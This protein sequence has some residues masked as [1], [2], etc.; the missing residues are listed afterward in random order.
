MKRRGWYR[1]ALLGAIAIVLL[2]TWL[3]ARSLQTLLSTQ[4]GLEH[5]FQVID[6]TR[7]LVA[8]V[9]TAEA[10]ARGY[11]LTAAPSFEQQFNNVS[12][13]VD[14][15][16]NQVQSLTADNT[17]QQQ[18]VAVL[19]QRIAAKMEVLRD[20]IAVRHGHP[21]G[22]IDPSLLGA[23]VR[24]TPDNLESVQ[25]SIHDIQ[26]DEVALLAQRSR[27]AESARRQVKISFGVAFFLDF[28]LLVAAFRLLERV[29]LRHDQLHTEFELRLARQ[30][31]SATFNQAAVGMA[32]TSTEGRFLL[33]NERL[34]ES[35]QTP[36][37][38][39]L[40][41]RLWDF[42]LPSERGVDAV[43]YAEMLAGSRLGYRVER[44]ILRKDGTTFP[45]QLTASLLQ[46]D[47]DSTRESA[48]AVFWVVEDITARKNAERETAELM[49]RL[50][51]SERL[52]AAGRMANTLAHEINNP[53]EALTNIV[54]LLQA[55]ELSPQAQELMS[56]AGRELDRVGHITRS[57]LSFYR[58]VPGRTLDLYSLLEEVVQ[59][60][61]S[62]ADQQHVEIITRYSPEVR[63]AHYD[64]ALRQVFANIV[65]NA[66][67]AMEGDGGRI[68]VRA[69]RCEECVVVTV[70]DSGH[71]IHP[72][73]RA[74]IFEPFF[75]TKGERGTG[76]GLWVTRGIVE[77]QGG[78]LHL[79]SNDSGPRRGTTI[80]ITL[81]AVSKA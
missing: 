68:V 79:R 66:L 2:N 24:D 16:L 45:A 65:G 41:L 20:G 56:I 35:L 38:R 15:S 13:G 7:R 73:N 11:I 31:F 12:G 28:V 9:R 26:A 47:G 53:L 37:D 77:E 10:A 80:R 70:S 72:A 40:M 64:P 57:T 3:A 49:T 18:R 69:R 67:E 44:T 42:L 34:A 55:Q 71:G 46:Q 1:T 17:R 61:Q 23:V 52:A 19:R 29:G 63:A 51:N 39:L 81:P 50:I 30:R 59:L 74:S 48:P 21:T 54:Y 78:K 22:T 75:T 58:K 27:L 14:D 32:H 4:A 36:A 5:S 62:R 8:N 6:N 33:V 43:L 60:F 76:L 25:V